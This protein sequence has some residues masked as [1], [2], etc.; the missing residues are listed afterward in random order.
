[1][2]CTLGKKTY[3]INMAEPIP[4]PEALKPKQIIIGETPVYFTTPQIIDGNTVEQFV[5]NDNDTR[6]NSLTGIGTAT[7]LMKESSRKQGERGILIDKPLLYTNKMDPVDWDK[8]SGIRYTDANNEIHDIPK[9]QLA[10]DPPSHEATAGTENQLPVEI[11]IQEEPVTDILEA[12]NA[13]NVLENLKEDPNTIT[14][15]GLKAYET[16]AR[17][18]AARK[19]QTPVTPAQKTWPKRKIKF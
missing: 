18:L 15:V 8:V 1:M 10:F 14:I 7:I 11:P 9:D 5:I 4:T 17:D 13:R 12:A 3:P 6:A 2:N 19:M 16:R